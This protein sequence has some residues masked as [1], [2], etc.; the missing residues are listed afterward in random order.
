MGLCCRWLLAVWCVQV[1]SSGAAQ[2]SGF[3]TAYINVSFVSPD[4]NRTIW[5]REE[6][7]L[8]G[9]ESPTYPVTGPVYLADPIHAC[10]N[11]TKFDRPAGS[12]PWIALVQRGNG[13]TF[14]YK[15]NAVAR[16]G[17]SAAVI[18]N[19]YGTDNLVIQMSHPGTS[20]VALM[21]GNTRGMNLVKLL[22]NGV[23]ISMTIEVGLQRGL[24]MS[25]YS[26]LFISIS[27]FIITTATV[28]YFIFYFAQRLNN[29]RQRNQKQKQMKAK[30]KKAIGQLKIRTLQQGDQTD[31]EEQHMSTVA[32]DLHSFPSSTEFL[33]THTN[34]N[35]HLNS[36]SYTHSD[37]ASSGHES[38]HAVEQ[39]GPAEH[40]HYGFE[41]VCVEMQPHYDNPAFENETRS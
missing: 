33:H 27:F 36:E 5:R 10:A 11:D 13:C 38:V 22:Q 31:V 35:T 32:S 8:Y 1:C 28:C 9:I 18:F 6:M 24:W 21:I 7:G 23:S 29:I 4:Y 30:A 2:V 26:V 3:S 34:S 16:N 19:D 37:A 17:A 25:H 12:A 20:I 40:T 39:L 15:I 14:T 41:A